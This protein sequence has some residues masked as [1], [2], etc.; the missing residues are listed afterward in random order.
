MKLGLPFHIN[1]TWAKCFS[2]LSDRKSS[3]LLLCRRRHRCNC[4]HFFL[5]QNTNVIW[6]IWY[7]ASFAWACSLLGTTSRVSNVATRPLVCFSLYCRVWLR[8]IMVKG[9]RETG[10][11]FSIK[12]FW[13]LLEIFLIICWKILNVRISD[14][15][16]NRNLYWDLDCTNSLMH[17]IYLHLILL[18]GCVWK[19]HD[20]YSVLETLRPTCVKID[21]LFLKSVR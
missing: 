19:L 16:E 15:Y 9:I 20:S 5:L 6:I 8:L 12:I 3:M 18:V 11:F 1:V 7:N 14:R 21:P 10:V 17:V 13:G 2:K 4:F